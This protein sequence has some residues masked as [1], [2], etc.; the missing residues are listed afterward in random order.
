LLTV[1]LSV[2]A[3]SARAQ[4]ADEDPAAM[5]YA[6]PRQTLIPGQ[7]GMAGGF[8]FMVNG[9]A[10]LDNP[11]LSGYLIDTPGTGRTFNAGQTQPLL[12][13]DWAMGYGRDAHGWVEGL[14][15]LNFGR[16]PWGRPVIPSWDSR[17]RGCGTPSTH[18]SS[19]TRR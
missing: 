2:G 9:F 18:T 10:H 12:T 8:H 14:L 19:C 11:G 16:P 6:I 3:A 15:M 13:D 5:P 4:S 17:A 7:P 1:V